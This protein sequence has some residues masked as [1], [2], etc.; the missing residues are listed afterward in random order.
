MTT[1]IQT[2]GCAPTQKT[3]ANRDRN[4]LRVVQALRLQGAS[5][6]GVKT[7]TERNV[8]ELVKNR[9]MIAVISAVLTAVMTHVAVAYPAV[10]AAMCVS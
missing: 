10:Y 6:L 4:Q 1:G 5:S 7:L 3:L 9:A 2:I 8:M